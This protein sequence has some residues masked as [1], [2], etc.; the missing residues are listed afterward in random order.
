MTRK[1]KYLHFLTT[2]SSYF[3]IA[4]SR[5]SG[6]TPQLQIF[7]FVIFSKI[8]PRLKIYDDVIASNLWFGPLPNKNPAYAYGF[9]AL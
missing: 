8:V 9:A 4:K 2:S 3:P 5:L 1:V 7:H 6:N